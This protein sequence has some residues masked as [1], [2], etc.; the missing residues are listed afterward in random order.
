[1]RRLRSV[2]LPFLLA[3]LIGFNLACS[4]RASQSDTRPADERAIR[5]AV[6]EWSKAAGAKDVEKTLSFYAENASLLPPHAPIAT[7]KD[8]IRKFWAGLMAT[9]GYA[10]SWSAT[11]V[12]ASKSG[13]VAYEVG[14]YELTLN[15]PKGKPATGRGKYV[16]VWKKQADGAWK[17][18]ADM[19]NPDQ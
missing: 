19:F 3:G 14:T 13:D 10:I 17:G 6:V 8:P 9:P 15:D 4:E 1:M 5:D 18:V 7:G 2:M 12:E 16:V 11:K